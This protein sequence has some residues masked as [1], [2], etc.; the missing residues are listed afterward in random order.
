MRTLI[1]FLALAGS[2]VACDD[3]AANNT[4]MDAPPAA[5]PDCATYCTAIQ[6]NCTTTNAQYPDPAHCM[7]ACAAFDVGTTGQT[8]GNTLGCRIY[9]AGMPAMT[10]PATHCKHAGPGGDATSVVSGAGTC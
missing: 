7:A 10:D 1:L 8:S 6:A 4:Q 3:K 2:A 5:A 9:H